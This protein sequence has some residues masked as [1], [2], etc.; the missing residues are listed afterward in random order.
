MSNPMRKVTGLRTILEQLNHALGYAVPEVALRPQVDGLLRP[1][2][3]DEEWEAWT[4]ELAGS[5]RNA[6]KKVP[7][8][9][10]EDLVQWTITERGRVLL[11]TF[12]K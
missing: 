12:P 6:I 9:F 2:S 4:A 7:S 8:D 11:L 10:D 5:Q 3:T 1:S